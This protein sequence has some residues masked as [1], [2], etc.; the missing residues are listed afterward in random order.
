MFFVLLVS[1]TLWIKNYHVPHTPCARHA[2]AY[3]HA[4]AHVLVNVPAHVFTHAHALAH[5]HVLTSTH[6]HINVTCWLGYRTLGICSN[7]STGSFYFFRF[8]II[9]IVFAH[10]Q[11]RTILSLGKLA[12]YSLSSF[13]TLMF[14]HGFFKTCLCWSNPFYDLR[15]WSTKQ[16]KNTA[17]CNLKWTEGEK[18]TY[19]ST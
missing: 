9:M 16:G 3:P 5:A 19:S 6:T 11:F 15:K 1:F 18:V 17:V 13:Q 14:A 12:K 2:H 4:H 7:F 8:S 10:V